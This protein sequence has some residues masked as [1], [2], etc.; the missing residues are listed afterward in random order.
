[1]SFTSFRDSGHV[2]VRGLIKHIRD[3]GSLEN[4]PATRL[5]LP[6]VL[7]TSVYRIIFLSAHHRHCRGDLTVVLLKVP[8]Q[9]ILSYDCALSAG[10]RLYFGVYQVYAH[11]TKLCYYVCESQCCKMIAISRAFFHTDYNYTLSE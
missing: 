7:A 4:S 6:N 1:M 9:L 8:S 5:N 2:A 11:K 3:D 10:K